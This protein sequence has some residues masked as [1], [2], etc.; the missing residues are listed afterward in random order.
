MLFDFLKKKEKEPEILAE[1][2]PNV[3]A[4]VT[5]VVLDNDLDSPIL[6]VQMQDYSE[7][8]IKSLCRILDIL[9]SDQSV[10]EAID[11]IKEAM[12]NDGNGD[13]IMKVFSQISPSTK[14][15]M[16]KGL[17]VDADNEPCIKPSE[18][19]MNK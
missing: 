7:E 16:L 18:I 1:D 4:S 2:G 19:F 12:I 17:G 5:F 14:M 9:A 15:K 8:S 13:H 10:V 11:I 6:D 3:L